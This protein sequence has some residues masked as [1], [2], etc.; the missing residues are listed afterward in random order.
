MPSHGEYTAIISPLTAGERRERESRVITDIAERK[1]KNSILS[2]CEHGEL[3]APG[4][5][6]RRVSLELD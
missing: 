4:T 1:Y 2:F 6:T 3:L 5:E